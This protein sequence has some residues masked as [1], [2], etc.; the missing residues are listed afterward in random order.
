MKN[1]TF[2]VISLFFSWDEGKINFDQFQFEKKE[3]L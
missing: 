2:L 1:K 3:E